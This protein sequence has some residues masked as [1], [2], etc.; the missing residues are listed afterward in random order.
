MGRDEPAVG[1]HNPLFRKAAQV[2][3][4][5]ASGKF[6]RLWRFQGDRADLLI[7]GIWRGLLSQNGAEVLLDI[8]Q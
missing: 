7:E 6:E 8:G 3:V 5:V 4:R 2:L 1:L